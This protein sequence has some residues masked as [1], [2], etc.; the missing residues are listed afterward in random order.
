MPFT[1]IDIP[2]DKDNKYIVNFPSISDR[3]QCVFNFKYSSFLLYDALAM[4]HSRTTIHFFLE[5]K[6]A[7]PKFC[8]DR[9]AMSM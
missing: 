2:A 5:R 6:L 4:R 1:S 9:M 3:D 7:L 8:E